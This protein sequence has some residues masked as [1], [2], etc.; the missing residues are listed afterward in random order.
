MEC[1][2]PKTQ[3]ILYQKSLACYQENATSCK[4]RRH[5]IA[6]PENSDYA[7]HK[8]IYDFLFECEFF[9]VH[10]ITDEMLVLRSRSDPSHNVT[11]S[12]AF[13]LLDCLAG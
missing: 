4:G 1:Q 10:A 3:P 9:V 11:D 8:I 2:N 6:T 12:V 7:A 13:Q 5:S